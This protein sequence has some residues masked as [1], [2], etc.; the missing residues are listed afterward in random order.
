MAVDVRSEKLTKLV[1]EAVEVRRLGTGFT[2]TEG[3]IWHPR[4]APP[5]QRHARRHPAQVD[6]G[7]HGVEVMNP[8][9][10][11]NGMT[12]TPT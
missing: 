5:V 2:F 4:G 1:D 10:K 7:R 12:W 6:A 9:N 8:S 3:P 11:C